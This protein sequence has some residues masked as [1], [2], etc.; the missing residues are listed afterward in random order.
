MP[1]IAAI[2]VFKHRR[3]CI[4]FSL[5]F[6]Y[7]FIICFFF[8]NG[9]MKMCARIGVC[10]S[11]SLQ[12]AWSKVVHII[13]VRRP[14]G[15]VLVPYMHAMVLLWWSVLAPR[16]RVLVHLPMLLWCHFLLVV[17]MGRP[18]CHFILL[19]LHLHFKDLVLMRQELQMV[20][21]LHYLPSLLRQ[22]RK[23]LIHLMQ[24]RRVDCRVVVDAPPTL[25][26]VTNRRAG[27]VT[28]RYQ[29]LHRHQPIRTALYGNQLQDEVRFNVDEQRFVRPHRRGKQ[30]APALCVLWRF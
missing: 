12:L 7:V 23:D 27:L 6:M 24:L 28:R 11:A 26:G 2:I 15:T 18:V 16:P 20:L 13:P 29:L 4:R 21:Q 10:S 9:E 25:R 14:L 19:L 8:Q 3:A 1:K 30:M 5:L 17:T 22:H